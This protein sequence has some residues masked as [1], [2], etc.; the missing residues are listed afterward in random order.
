MSYDTNAMLL[1]NWMA[2]PDPGVSSNRVPNL[3]TLVFV[4][5]PTPSAGG[6]ARD[7]TGTRSSIAGM[8]RIA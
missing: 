7:G 4:H 3:I 5:C 8:S 6:A 2:V 1:A